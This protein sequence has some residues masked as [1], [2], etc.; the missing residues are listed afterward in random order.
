MCVHPGYCCAFCRSQSVISNVRLSRCKSPPLLL[1]KDLFKAHSDVYISTH[2]LQNEDVYPFWPQTAPEPRRGEP[3]C[4]SIPLHFPSRVMLFSLIDP[5]PLAVTSSFPVFVLFFF[6]PP[7]WSVIRHGVES[8]FF[9]TFS[10]GP[11]RP[12][13]CRGGGLEA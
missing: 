11:G 9:C 10:R 1:F 12:E 3:K 4:S 8:G 5:S 13:S 2:V 6:L 7:P